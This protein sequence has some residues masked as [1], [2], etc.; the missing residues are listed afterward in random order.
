MLK[1][2][3]SKIIFISILL[4]LLVCTVVAL[5]SVSSYFKDKKAVTET[6]AVK[7][8]YFGEKIN[9]ILSQLT[10]TARNLA[11]T[12]TVFYN[13]NDRDKRDLAVS[14][15]KTF[16]I[17]DVSVGGGVWF[18][19][20]T[21][22]NQK[23]FC[24]YAM[25]ENND[26]NVVIDPSFGSVQ[27]DYPNQS[28]YKF[29]KEE[30]YS[31]EGE[32]F[33]FT[34]P[35]IDETGT[36][37]L[38]IT[39]GASIFDKNGKFVGLTTVD[40]KMDEIIDAVDKLKPTPS[41]FALFADRKNDFIIVLNDDGNKNSSL[42]ASL[43]T[44]PWYKKDL[45]SGSEF[46]YKGNKYVSF[47]AEL[48]NNMILIVN[49]PTSELY[50][51]LYNRFKILTVFILLSL[52]I[53]SL[54]MYFVL[55]NNV[56]KPVEY[57]VSMA[58]RIGGGDLDSKME[59]SS[60]TEFALLASSFNKMTTDIKD[61]ITNLDRANS[62]K[63]LMEEELQIAKDIQTSALPKIFPPYPDRKNFDIFASMTPAKEVGGDFYDFFFVDENKFAFLIADV[64][65]KGVPA[66]LF[67]MSAKT[68][69]KNL[70]Q[71][72]LSPAE[73]LT[74]V[75]KELCKDNEKS[76]FVTLF[77]VQVDL[78]T[79][80]AQYVNAG[81]NPPLLKR[82]GGEFEYFK[83]SPNFVLGA[84]DALEYKSGS[85]QLNAGDVF[86]LYTDGVTEAQNYSKEFFGEDRLSVALN[87]NTEN[88]VNSIISNVA[89]YI[90]DFTQG[91]EQYDDVTML[92]FI[93]NGQDF[94]KDNTWE[95]KTFSAKAEEFFNI[96]SWVESI[97]DDVGMDMKIKAKFNVALEEIFIN[98]VNYAYPGKE[99]SVDIS[100]RTDSNAIEVRFIDSG[101]PYNPLEQEAPDTS[102]NAQDRQI[103][104]LGIFIVRNTMDSM[105]YSFENGKNILTI[106]KNF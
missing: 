5:L 44:I 29:I 80:E 54:T 76:Y 32:D 71:T 3:K 75:N 94:D 88:S 104:G 90:C 6:C 85:V 14:A 63:K 7:V 19:P 41:S 82:N 60:P 35:Y 38:M 36:N 64:S 18:E 53:L 33:S 92:S 15:I 39:I 89:N 81:H 66:A 43:K 72:K 40:W 31:N 46:V 21:V 79:G 1:S 28:W 93:Y 78:K 34:K 67:M 22:N 4:L 12:G 95:T 30:I 23:Y 25:D 16:E 106:K 96:L 87:S 77:Y 57:L 101:I 55:V 86:F 20:Y 59:I 65:G 13:S 98:I 26:N 50:A 103:G 11:V 99:G 24:T 17:D 68:L 47:L 27:Y 91:A 83:T 74:R 51:E 58:E 42:G 45:K 105:E 70:A 8:S 73:M 2:L 56:K 61:Y 100:L 52:F 84:F 48:Q 9:K 69:I 10:S 37:S 49:V 102:L 62:E 97:C